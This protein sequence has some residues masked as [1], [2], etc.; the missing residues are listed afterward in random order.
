MS[1]EIICL[2]KKKKKKKKKIKKQKNEKIRNRN[3]RYFFF[4]FS[5]STK[6][7]DRKC[8]QMHIKMDNKKIIIKIYNKIKISN[9]MNKQENDFREVD[10]NQQHP[11][12]ILYFYY[13]NIYIDIF[14]DYIYI[15]VYIQTK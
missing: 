11:L 10:I 4:F 1:Q 12:F 9:E 7:Q 15:Y 14:V 13:F 6:S 2:Q 8:C 5:F 3:I